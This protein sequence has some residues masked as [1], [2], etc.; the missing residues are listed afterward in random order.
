M[1]DPDPAAAPDLATVLNN[2]DRV[3]RSTDIPLF[4]GIKGKDN[5]SAQQ[6]V[7]RIDR[8][9]VIANWDRKTADGDAG[10]AAGLVAGAKRRCDEL[11]L[12]LR[13]KAMSWYHTLED[14]PGFNSNDWNEITREFLEAYAPKYTART[15]CVSLQEL[16]QRGE[17]NVQD[18]YNRVSDSFRN[19]YQVKHDDLRNFTGPAIDRGTAT[20]AQANAINLAGVQKMQRNMMNTIFLGGLREELRSKVLEDETEIGDIRSSVK[21]A[22]AL[23]IL[24]NEKRIK[25]T[26]IASL[27]EGEEKESDSLEKEDSLQEKIRAAVAAIKLEEEEEQMIA[28]LGSNDLRNKL[29]RG[30]TSAR[31]GGYQN[32]NRGGGDYKPNGVFVCWYCNI[33]GHTQVQCR[34]RQAEGGSFV[35]RGKNLVVHAITSQTSEYQKIQTETRPSYGPTAFLKACLN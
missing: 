34:K 3:K 16:R 17:E 6:L 25:G 4:Y 35:T 22:R 20:V 5:V 1:A 33:S 27:T 19:A 15:L 18:F 23:E 12:C 9:A 21:R 31:R 30:K 14:I 11:Y 26:V 32:S 29:N 2:H 24:V 7:D 8:A 10:I 13:E 28:A